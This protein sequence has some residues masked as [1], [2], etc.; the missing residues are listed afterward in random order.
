[1]Q[2]AIGDVVRDRSDFALGTVA[3]I[4]SQSSGNLVALQL[5]GGAVRLV[6]PD[7]LDLVARYAKPTTTGRSVMTLA[8][9]VVAVLAAYVG[10]RSALN[11]G[12]DWPLAFLMG[13]G[14]HTAVMTAFQWWLRLTGPRRFRV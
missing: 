14:Y 8:V 13:L 5:S 7:D 9:L 12:A 2:L 4:A 11:L 6:E 1:M 3:G 10:C